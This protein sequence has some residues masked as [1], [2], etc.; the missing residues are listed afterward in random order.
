MAAVTAGLATASACFTFPDPSDQSRD[1]L[2]HDD[3]DC[4]DGYACL[5]G[6]CAY[7]SVTSVQLDV[8]GAIPPVDI[9]VVLDNSATMEAAL[10]EVRTNLALF[11]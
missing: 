10:A 1:Y 3:S 8:A 7:G 5:R 11:V 2:C 6:V 9:L 4:T